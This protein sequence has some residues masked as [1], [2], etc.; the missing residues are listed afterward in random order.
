MFF[1]S[2]D[3]KELDTHLHNI[4]SFLTTEIRRANLALD[5][6]V[7]E[8]AGNPSSSKDGKDT[9][10]PPSSSREALTDFLF[11]IHHTT[12]AT[13]VQ[14]DR[15][16]AVMD[17]L[18]Q[19]CDDVARKHADQTSRVSEAARILD[20]IR[21]Q[22][23]LTG[24]RP[25]SLTELTEEQQAVVR[26]DVNDS[27]GQKTERLKSRK[28]SRQFDSKGAEVSEE[29]TAS[30]IYVS[31]RHGSVEKG[32]SGVKDHKK[33]ALSH[34]DDSTGVQLT[35]GHDPTREHTAI[36]DGVGSLYG[37]ESTSPLNTVSHRKRGPAVTMVK[38]LQQLKEMLNQKDIDEQRCVL[39]LDNMLVDVR[40]RREAMTKGCGIYYLSIICLS[41][42]M[43]AHR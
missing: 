10:G 22:Q 20:D 34:S 16:R 21:Q 18:H 33:R 1:F 43:Y 6:D 11:R 28:V 15:C 39:V 7:T 13:L 24:A 26:R 8:T 5:D 14:F 35:E 4:T 9:S 41:A 3:Y 12:R 42:E 23:R 2:L 29:H 30:G 37:T 31:A 32:E 19:D 40:Q 27:R 36:T 38:Q 25:W 17:K